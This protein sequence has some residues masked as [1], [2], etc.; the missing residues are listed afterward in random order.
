[1]GR[2]YF[3]QRSHEKTVWKR[4]WNHHPALFWRKDTNGS[5]RKNR[6]LP[7][8]GLPSLLTAAISE[9]SRWNGRCSVWSRRLSSPCAAWMSERGIAAPSSWWFC[10]QIGLG[11]LK[12]FGHTRS[13]IKEITLLH[14][15]ILFY[16]IQRLVR[17]S[18]EFSITSAVHTE[19]TDADGKRNIFQHTGCIM[20]IDLDNFREMN[21]KFGHLAGDY[22]LKEVADLLKEVSRKNIVCR[23]GGDEF[24]YYVDGISKQEEAEN[25]VPFLLSSRRRKF[26]R[27]WKSAWP[28]LLPEYSAANCPEEKVKLILESFETRKNE[29]SMLKNI[30]LSIGISLFGVDGGSYGESFISLKL[31]KSIIIMQPLPFRRLSVIS[32]SPCSLPSSPVR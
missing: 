7:G 26:Y 3:P 11:L 16:M 29:I 17:F 4:I 12:R 13:L 5:R 31:S 28:Y 8:S 20:M 23:M 25:P 2:T 27:C 22:V 21:D 10:F 14:I 24:L 6:H 32:F 15:I 9:L 1:M 30:S 19:K 18:Y